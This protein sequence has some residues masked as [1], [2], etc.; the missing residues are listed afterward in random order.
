MR[1]RYRRKGTPKG[2]KHIWKYLGRWNERKTGPRTWNISFRATKRKKAG[3][4][5]RF[6]KG[7]KVA[8]R[9]RAI[10]R[11][12]KTGKGTYQTHMKGT[13]TLISTKSPRKR[14]WY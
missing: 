14:K 4:Y 11:A 13:K 3:R 7:F 8:W 5:G 1:K 12:T 9:I 2:F 10:Q 6:R